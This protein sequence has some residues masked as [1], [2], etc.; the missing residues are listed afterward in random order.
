MTGARLLLART[1]TVAVAYAVAGKLALLMAI[2]PGY[3]TA[4]WPSA[5]IALGTTLSWGRAV[6]PGVLLGSFLVNV[7]TSLGGT[8]TEALLRSAG[9]ALALGVGAALQATAGAWL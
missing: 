1:L 3:A 5:G 6:V 9:V 4:V 2:P 8:G 7:S